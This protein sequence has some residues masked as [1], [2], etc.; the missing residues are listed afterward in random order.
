MS[1]QTEGVTDGEVTP[2]RPVRLEVVSGPSKPPPLMVTAGTL[3]AGSHRSCDF[4]ISDPS[5]SRQHA[6]LELLSS[7]VRVV[8]LGSTNGVRYLGARVK[9]AVVPLGGEVHLGRTVIRLSAAEPAAT[10]RRE[11]LGPLVGSS[12]PMQQLYRQLEQLAP[13][14]MNVLILGE[15]GTGKGAVAEALHGLSPVAKQPLVVF[16]C[17]ATN[18]NLI[19][20]ALFGHARGAF[21]GA[22]DA[23]AGAFEQA[24]D[25]TLLLD[26][27]GELPLEL[28]PKLL[29]ALDSRDFTRVGEG[30]RRK[31]G[32]RFLAATHRDLE[33]MVNAG[34]FRSDLYFRLAQAVV[35]VPPLRAR[36]D[37]VPLLVEHLLERHRRGAKTT[38]SPATLAALRGERWPGN[39]RELA[40]AVE[41]ALT[42][43]DFRALPRAAPGTA[44][45]NETRDEVVDAFE[46]EYL[47]ALIAEHR[48]NM[49]AVARAADLAR[50]QLY[51]LLEKHGLTPK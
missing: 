32:C 48:G 14:R 42:L 28:Q 5:V 19:D 44:S 45:F 7:G 6:R 15:T 1:A 8:D 25:G 12:E 17:G 30:L 39:V 50:S 49:S 22:V 47:A 35:T 26:E 3:V 41:R 43:G 51:R 29:R 38:L 10:E 20:S 27:I 23:R 18:P 4:V 40:N 13:G 16:D 46:R 21:T 36:R 11:R 33:A 37:D 34:R 9:E 24:L 31:I 2:P